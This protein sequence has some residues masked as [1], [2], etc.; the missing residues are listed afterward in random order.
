[1][2]S[3]DVDK[4][5][6]DMLSCMPRSIPYYCDDSSCLMPL[7]YSHTHHSMTALGISFV[8]YC[9]SVARPVG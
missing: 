9:G 7:P 6:L 2:S 3:A 1:V 4:E 8:E 5:M